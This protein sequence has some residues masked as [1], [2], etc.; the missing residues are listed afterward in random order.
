MKL[1]SHAQQDSLIGD[2][3]QQGALLDRFD[4]SCTQEIGPRSKVARLP[5]YLV[6]ARLQL[7][8]GK[9]VHLTA[10]VV[11]D[12]QRQGSGLILRDIIPSPSN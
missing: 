11:E 5:G 3:L 12:H 6:P 1:Y 10:G 8:L 4:V 7:A 9:P 2:L